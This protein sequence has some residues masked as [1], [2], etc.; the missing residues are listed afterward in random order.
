MW[1]DNEA[2]LLTRRC[3]SDAETGPQ[4]EVRFYSLPVT[5]LER[6]G[7]NRKIMMRHKNIP[8]CGVMAVVL[9]PCV[10]EFIIKRGTVDET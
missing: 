6:S 8:A 7:S 2:Y 4:Q 10:E 5:K 3:Q 1:S 9:L